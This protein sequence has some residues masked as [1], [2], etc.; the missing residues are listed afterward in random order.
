MLWTKE[1]IKVQIFRFF[2]ALMKVHPIPDAS[3]ETA[4]SGF[5]QILHH[6]S[7]SCLL[8]I[9][10]SQNFILWTKRAHRSEIFRP[11]S[12]CVKM[13]QI[14]YV[15]FETASQ[16]FFELFITLQCH[17]KLFCTILAETVHDL[18]HQSA[19]FQTFDCSCKISPNLYFHRLL[20]LKVYKILA[21]KIQRSYV[22]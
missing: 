5:I 2:S 8:C 4:R 3:F 1:P 12:G 17:E 14:P 7:V 22:S 16:F 9:F 18:A 10:L 11:L 19:K 20:L 15:M 6:C 21:K 13:H